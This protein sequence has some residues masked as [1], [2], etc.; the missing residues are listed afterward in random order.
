MAKVMNAVFSE[1]QLSQIALVVQQVIGET[2][3]PEPADNKLQ[4][5]YTSDGADSLDS[6]EGELIEQLKTE[7][8][9]MIRGRNGG[10]WFYP[11]EQK[12]N[13]IQNLRK[14]RKSYR[15]GVHQV[16]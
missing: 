12:L 8:P 5:S 2:V 14:N 6:I 16:K 7:A 15:D 13:I 4:V 10:E 1:E 11:S 3:T 9:V